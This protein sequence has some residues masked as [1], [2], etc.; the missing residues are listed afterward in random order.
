MSIPSAWDLPTGWESVDY[1]PLLDYLQV[2]LS[3]EL[4]IRALC[5][6]S[7]AYEHPGIPHNERL[8]F[9]GDSVLSICV[10]E[11]LFQQYPDRSEGELAKMR[12]NIVSG[13]S[14]AR[15]ALSLIHI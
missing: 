1:Q 6:R 12:A 4:L 13:F 14:L 11:Q 7:Y 5:H 3:R 9:L 2:D 10:T 15:L 8:E